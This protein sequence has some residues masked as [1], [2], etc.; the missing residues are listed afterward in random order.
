MLLGGSAS[1]TTPAEEYR[2][3]INS[4]EG[5]SVTTPG[6]GT[7]SYDAGKVVDLVATPDA[8]YRF[9]GWTGDAG[10]IANVTAPS[11]TI[12][13]S[14]DYSITANFAKTTYH[15]RDYF[16]TEFPGVLPVGYRYHVADNYTPTYVE[17]YVWAV[18]QYFETT[19]PD[20]L[21]FVFT[22]IRDSQYAGVGEYASSSLGGQFQHNL[23]GNFYTCFYAGFPSNNQGNFYMSFMLP[24]TFISGDNWVSG[25][26]AYRVTYVG[27]QT[28]GTHTFNNCIEVT[29]DDSSN[30]EYYQGKGYFVLASGIGIVKLVF[31]RTM[32]AADGT[33]VSYEIDQYGFFPPHTI[34]GVVL[35]STVPVEGI[36]VGISNA[37]WGTRCVT[38]S[39]GQF[40]ITARGPDVV[41]RIWY[42][43]D[44]LGQCDDNYFV[45]CCSYRFCVDNIQGNVSNLSIDI[46]N[47]SVCP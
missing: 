11:T 14:G 25:T 35:N 26:K 10:T 7:H 17:W 18:P 20:A 4:T 46:G 34:S 2:L 23:G 37:D 30:Q 33:T 3:T 19:K 21:D 1:C 32:G 39:N 24:V 47:A 45:P 9:V 40:S 29:I 15:S 6:E 12:I 5:G 13:M 27:T 16:P 22:L 42:E 44:F 38:N 43:N 36:S 31:K 28:V 8:D 41:L